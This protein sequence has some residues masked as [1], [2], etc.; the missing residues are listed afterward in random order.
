[1]HA[2]HALLLLALAALVGY[3]VYARMRSRIRAGASRRSVA[4]AGAALAFAAG[5]ALALVVPRHV[6]ETPGS[7]ATLVAIAL[8]WIVGG[9]LAFVGLAAFLGAWFA[10]AP[11]ASSRA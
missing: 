7:P 2:L 6:P 11:G 10:R 8:L 4:L 3:P 1:V 9:S 5:L